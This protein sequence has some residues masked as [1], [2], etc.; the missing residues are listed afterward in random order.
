MAA[1]IGGKEVGYIACLIGCLVMIAGRFLSG[2]P[3]ALIYVGLAIILLGWALFAR[4]R[5]QRAAQT[6]ASTMKIDS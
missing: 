4:A 2:A 6:R 1:R 3:H 5:F